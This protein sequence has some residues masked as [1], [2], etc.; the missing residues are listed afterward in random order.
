MSDRPF[1]ACAAL[2]RA[3]DPDRYFSALFAPATRRPFLFALYALNL[4]LARVG[5]SV[6]EPMLGEIRLQWWRE[7]LAEARAGRPRR[8]DV[9][10]AMAACFADVELPEALFDRMIDA[11][12]F[13]FS[14]QDFGDIAALEAYLSDT[15]GSL[16][17][18]AGRALGVGGAFDEAA[19]HAGIAFGLVGTARALAF[20]GRR[21]KSF[22]PRAM[23]SAAGISRSDLFA[24]SGRAGLISV[25]REMSRRAQMLHNV[26]SATSASGAALPALLPAALVPLYA[27]HTLR[28]VYDPYAPEIGLHRRMA[29]LFFAAM[30]RRI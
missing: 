11:R 27:K 15:S 24:K 23:L 12:A 28:S 26:V 5:E 9:A 22:V 2:V 7:A 3:G 30:R 21:E 4:E 8:H 10:E 16:M 1:E 29:T 19:L 6:R 18:L 20:H 17:R 14:P 13:D 25:A